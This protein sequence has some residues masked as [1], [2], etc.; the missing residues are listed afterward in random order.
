MKNV[1]SYLMNNT[2]MLPKK[3]PKI[4]PHIYSQLNFNKGAKII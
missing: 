4:N 3:R 2:K 1:D